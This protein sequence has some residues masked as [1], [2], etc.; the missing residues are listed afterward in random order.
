MLTFPFLRLPREPRDAKYEAYLYDDQGL[1]YH[2]PSSQLRYATQEKHPERVGLGLVCRAIANEMQQVRLS[3]NCITFTPGLSDDGGDGVEFLGL[4][5]K[6]GRFESL[7]QHVRVAKMYML[8]L[9]APCIIPTML[10]QTTSRY[11]SVARWFRAVFR[12]LQKGFDGHIRPA[13]SL[14]S[15][16]D[17]DVSCRYQYSAAFRDALQY[18]LTLARGGRNFEE[19]AAQS[20]TTPIEGY[21]AAPFVSGSH[22]ALLAWYP[23]QW[24]IPS[25]HD[26]AL[27]SRMSLPKREKD[28]YDFEH[29]QLVDWYF[30]AT[31]LAIRFLE[32]LPTGRRRHVRNIVINED[33]RGVGRSESH[34]RGLVPYLLQNSVLRIS[35]NVNIWQT[36]VPFI[37]TEHELWGNDYKETLVDFESFL[38]TVAEWIVETSYITATGLTSLTFI[39]DGN[40]PETQQVWENIKKAAALQEA[41]ET[42]KTCGNG[43]KIELGNV[44]STRLRALRALGIR[45]RPVE[46]NSIF[47][48]ARLQI[49]SDL[50]RTFSAAIKDIVHG[51]GIIQFDGDAG[52]MWDM[53][54]YAATR[55]K[56]SLQDFWTEW[57]NFRLYT[58]IPM[59]P[60]GAEAYFRQYN[61]RS[62]RWKSSKEPLSSRAS[63]LIKVILV[64]RVPPLHKSPS[65][66][67][68]LRVK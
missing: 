47:L 50:P 35:I 1:S 36:F 46:E 17:S 12:Q 23:E 6:A 32:A 53:D 58:D 67:Q 39:F 62:D 33:R 66:R 37:W 11:P 21:G 16:Y 43:R 13:Y 3:T 48:E 40:G 9:V 26:L 57:Y 61:R 65:K 38:P 10:D 20:C 34:A 45:E 24:L 60:G 5:S 29:P 64:H 31:A 25:E 2:Y 4:R 19:L 56:W 15:C 14:E 63:A 49:P 51:R 41:M 28:G 44:F 7:L 18:L 30:S 22:D 59:P 52:D 27:E 8:M 54:Q 55:S 42:S 68:A